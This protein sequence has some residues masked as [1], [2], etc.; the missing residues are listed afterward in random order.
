MGVFPVNLLHIFGTIFSKNTSGGLLLKRTRAMVRT[1]CFIKQLMF[2]VLLVFA[3]LLY[4]YYIFVC[5]SSLNEKGK[6]SSNPRNNLSDLLIPVNSKALSNSGN[7]NK[8]GC[9]TLD[10]CYNHNPLTLCHR[11]FISKLLHSRT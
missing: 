5:N 2:L 4:S 3:L 8:R 6:T 7:T 10:R 1:Y 11:Q 9:S